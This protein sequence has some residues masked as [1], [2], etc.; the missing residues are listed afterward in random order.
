MQVD[1]PRAIWDLVQVKAEL[2]QALKDL[3]G[4]HDR[5]RRRLL[6]RIR[7]LLLWVDEILATEEAAE[8]PPAAGGAPEPPSPLCP[9]VVR[10]LVSHAEG[11]SFL[12]GSSPGPESVLILRGGLGLPKGEEPC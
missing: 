11:R 1:A 12:D 4:A 8:G 9:A 7:L 5:Q 2:D 3:A 10:W 6:R